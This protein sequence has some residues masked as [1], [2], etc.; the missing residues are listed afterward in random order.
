VNVP[1]RLAEDE[2]ARPPTTDEVP[3]ASL[4]IVALVGPAALP[5]TVQLTL[6]VWPPATTSSSSSVRVI[7]TSISG[8]SGSFRVRCARL[9]LGLKAAAEDEVCI[10]RPD[11]DPGSDWNRKKVNWLT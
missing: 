4:V 7:I 5:E 8:I 6:A 11:R 2:G 1:E 9:G 3:V 10:P